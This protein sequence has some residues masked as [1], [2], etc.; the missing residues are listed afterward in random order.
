MKEFILIQL[1]IFGYLGFIFVDPIKNNSIMKTIL[2]NFFF[3][4]TTISMFSQTQFTQLGSD[5]DGENIGDG[6][7]RCVASSIDGSIVAVGAPYNSGNGNN[8]GHVRVYEFSNSSWSQLGSDIDGEDSLT[9]V[10]GTISL[11]DGGTILA[12][13]VPNTSDNGNNRGQVRVYEYSNSS[14]SQLGG[15]IDGEDSLDFSGAAVDLSGDGTIVAIGAFNNGGAGTGSGHVRVYQYSNSSWSQLGSDIDGENIN[16]ASGS[17]VSLSDD[18]TIVAI[19]AYG[20]DANGSNSGHVRVYEYSN[21]SWSQLGSDIDGEAEDDYSGQYISLS[22][23][24]TYLAVGAK[25]NDGNGDKSGHVRVYEYSNGSWLQLGNDID[26]DNSGERFGSSVS[27]SDSGLKLAVSA[28]FANL[29]TG[30]VKIFGY[31][32]GSW[33]QIDSIIDGEAQGDFSGTSISLSN[34]GARVVVGSYQNNNNTGHA[35]IFQLSSGIGLDDNSLNSIILSPNPNSG[36]FS[37]KV[38]QE[39]I[40][41]SYKILDN[42]GRLIDKGIIRELSKDLNL[43]DQPKGVYR[44]QVSNEKSVKTLNIVIQ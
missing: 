33:S 44:I 17:S 31:A 8:S 18:G 35:R 15:D 37:I 1:I 38:D 19:G 6:F 11:S 24:G 10:G 21:S 43:S 20:N 16:D 36:L 25:W 5:L 2:F 3:F 40:G 39:Y 32:N 29:Y 27:I 30:Y 14:W 13:G 41:S 28:P 7:G 42:L 23:D 22:A 34:D 26:G 9:F 12:I 4:V